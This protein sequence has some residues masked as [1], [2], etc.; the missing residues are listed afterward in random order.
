MS[1]LQDNSVLWLSL[2]NTGCSKVYV[3]D[4][5]GKYL[6]SFGSYGSGPRQFK[7]PSGISVDNFGNILVAD[8]K[9][10]RV[11]VSL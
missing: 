2:F 3:T 7:E 1:I 8:S 6:R 10:N 9:N 5:E 11:Q 4:M